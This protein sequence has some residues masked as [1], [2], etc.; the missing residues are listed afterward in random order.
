MDVDTSVNIKEELKD[1][2]PVVKV[3]TE[4]TRDGSVKMEDGGLRDGGVKMEEGEE[5]L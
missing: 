2:D 4:D 1:E 5:G 3:K